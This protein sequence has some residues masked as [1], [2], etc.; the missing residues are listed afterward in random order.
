MN[1]K[2]YEIVVI[3]A[4]PAGWSAALY[5]ARAKMSVLVI[6]NPAHSGLAD[7]A[8][9]WNYPG[10][11]SGVSGKQLLETMQQQATNQGA[12]FWN[13]E[14]THIEKHPQHGFVIRT[15]TRTEV[16]AKH[17]LL[18]H[19][20]NFIKVNLPGEQEL[21]GRGVHYCALCDGALYAGK[22]VVVLGHGNLAAEE[23]L[24]LK[25]LGVIVS[26]IITH[27][28]V[29]HISTEYQALLTKEGIEVEVGRAQSFAPGILMEVLTH[30]GTKQVDA[31]AVFIALGVAS[32]MTFAQKLGLEMNGNFLKA[33]GLGRTNVPGVWVAG[34]ARAGV[35]Q[36]AK[37]VGEGAAAAVDI[38]KTVKGLPQYIDHE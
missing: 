14:V 9:V 31:D 3:G 27:A 34:L 7:A 28:Q 10:V 35:N 26:R 4:G 11:Q 16:Y 36:I 25:A 32:S 37:S 29:A 30:T 21:V 18:A 19:G 12:V 33:D 2:T 38:I 23:A 13:D 8:E 17:V 1:I 15:S 6:G 5:L 20:A 22:K 24:Q